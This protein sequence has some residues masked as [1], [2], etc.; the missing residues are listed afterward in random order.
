MDKSNI[1]ET[2]C[3]CLAVTCV[4]RSLV[5]PGLLILERQA[6]PFKDVIFS[7]ACPKRNMSKII[8]RTRRSNQ[9]ESSPA[10]SFPGYLV[11]RAGLCAMP[12]AFQITQ[13]QLVLHC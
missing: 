2:V 8:Y 10:L 3:A 11:C 5:A 13:S 9:K 4:F 7:M 6:D 12:F 1:Y